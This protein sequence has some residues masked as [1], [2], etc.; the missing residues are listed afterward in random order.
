M[1]YLQFVFQYEG[2]VSLELLVSKPHNLSLWLLSTLS[3]FLMSD[4]WTVHPSLQALFLTSK[5]QRFS[6]LGDQSYFLPQRENRIYCSKSPQASHHPIYKSISTNTAGPPSAAGQKYS[7]CT[8]RLFRELD[9]LTQTFSLLYLYHFLPVANKHSHR[10]LIDGAPLSW[11]RHCKPPR[12][13]GRVHQNLN[14]IPFYSHL[15]S[16]L[17]LI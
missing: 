2:Q 8:M 13:A 10:G 1:S 11:K 14:C 15:S 6:L 9:P 7:T 4:V 5:S 12:M 3:L 16:P 17:Y